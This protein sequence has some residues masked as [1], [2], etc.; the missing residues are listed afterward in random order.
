MNAYIPLLSLIFSAYG[1][2]GQAFITTWKTDNPGNSAPNQITIPTTGTGYSYSIYWEDSS[3]A[4]INGIIPGPITGNHTITFP[5]PGTYRVHISGAFPRIYFNRSGTFPQNDKD[6]E[7]ILS[8]DQ[9]GNIVWGSMSGAFDGCKNLTIPAADAPNLAQATDMS[10]ML[11][12]ASS[13][14]QPVAHWD[15]SHITNMAS[16]FGGATSFNQPIA[17]WNVSNVT[18][19]SGMFR[20]VE[21][22]NQPI[23]T[24]DVSNVT[25]MSHMFSQTNFN[26]PIGDWNVSQVKN[27]N[28]MFYLAYDFN[29]PLGAW[30]VSNVTDMSAMFGRARNFNQPIGSWNVGA[31][32]NMSWMFGDQFGGFSSIFNQSI[33]TWNVRNVTNMSGMFAGAENF[34]Q[35]IGAWDVS[36]VTDMSYMFAGAQN[37][38]QPLVNW[39]VSQVINMEFLF[40]QAIQ[41][42]QPI[43]NWSVTNVTDMDGMFASALSFN[44]PIGNWDVSQVKSM[45]RMFSFALSFNQSLE[46]WKVES[47]EYMLEMFQTATSF[48]QSL[49]NWN[50][51]NVIDMSMMLSSSGLSTANYDET[52]IGWAAQNVKPNV[53]LG[54]LGL[55]YCLGAA[56]RAQLVS[57]GWVIT[58]DISLVPAQPVLDIVQPICFEETGTITVTNQNSN[59]AYSFDGGA[60]FQASPIKAGLMPGQYSILIK[61]ESGCLSPAQQATI[62]NPFPRSATP[63][64]SGSPIVCP[65]TVEVDYSGNNPNYMYQW[66]VKGGVIQQQQNHEIRVNWGDS[67]FNAFI[68]AIGFDERN[69]PT[70]TAVFPVKIQIQLKPSLPVGFDSVCYNFRAGVPYQTSYT[71]GSVYT[72]FTNGGTV[73]EGQSTSKAKIDWID[74]G[75]YQLWVKEE[76][77]TSTD[78]C[79][80]VSDTLNVTVFKDL[81]A[82]TMNFVSV[83]YADDKN[84]QLKWEISLLER[85]TDLIIVSRR[86]AGSNAPWVVIATLQKNV[87]SFLDQNLAT[88][89][90]V[91]EYKVE[92]FNKC[93]EGLQ[94]VIHNT[95][96]LEGD[97]VEEEELIYLDWNDYNGWDEVEHYEVWRK[98]DDELVYKLID[99]T[100]GDL[101]TYSGK[102]GADGFVHHLRIKAKKKGANTIS[103]SNE[104]ELDFENPIDFIPNIITPNGDSK[105]DFF[106]IPKLH[107]YPDNALMVY[108]RWGKMVFSK[109]NYDNTWN[110]EGLSSGVYFYTII[111][112]GVQKNLKGWLHV[113]R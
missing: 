95:I 57:K 43:G 1:A 74:I 111:I 32:E 91:Y 103:W 106:V 58:G 60:T 67:N 36:N 4:A 75:L 23:G 76:N 90:N 109:K 89:S 8:L 87:Q 3:D 104:I 19:M 34:N 72:W 46:S 65:N 18:N 88:K 11:Y 9:W 59:E 68:K 37:F 100:P 77:T 105:N 42:N 7:K 54:A 70:D 22:F 49:K 61:G 25:D 98:L 63:I 21:N 6:Y 73:A 16:L 99:V 66:F 102:H 78:Y 5:A 29:Q 107:L 12:N 110:A 47:V 84:V 81:A 17:I 51:G 15:V 44:H 86:I 96:K 82:I 14:N 13:F 79:E 40:A 41:F 55:K 53:P 48:N 101:T 83:D 31:V 92:G 28:S 97:K 24:W 69:C 2:V 38:N 45:W 50:I 113:I 20:Y 30:N 64:L 26:Q 52:L 94:T 93:D 80:G 71:N 62:T 27:M 33:D 112:N 85:V 108:D 35:P 39:D 10:W 56:A